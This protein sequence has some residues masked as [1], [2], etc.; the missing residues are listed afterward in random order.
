[1]ANAAERCALKASVAANGARRAATS[2]ANAA[3]VAGD[4]C[5][6]TSV[7]NQSTVST[8]D[9]LITATCA[10]TRAESAWGEAR[11]AALLAEESRVSNLQV[12]FA[13]SEL[14]C[15]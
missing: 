6:A 1:M 10:E 13:L 15:Q 5:A 4:L 7:G 3:V 8:L 2:A 9:V 14:C 12:C 11:L